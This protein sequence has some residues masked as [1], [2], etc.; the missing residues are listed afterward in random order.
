MPEI[1]GE[2]G[3]EV[4]VPW[5]PKTAAEDRKQVAPPKDG[6]LAYTE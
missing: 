1:C 6:A 3:N 2:I 4:N 5:F